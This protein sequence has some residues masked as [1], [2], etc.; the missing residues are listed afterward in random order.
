MGTSGGG[1]GRCSSTDLDLLLKSHLENDE[2]N[3]EH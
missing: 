3:G 2:Q 1:L